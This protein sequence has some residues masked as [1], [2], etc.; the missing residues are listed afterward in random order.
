MTKERWLEAVDVAKVT[1]VDIPK[2][3]CLIEELPDGR[4]R[5]TYTAGWEQQYGSPLVNSIAL[6]KT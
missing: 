3:M 1:R 4:L 5:C 6:V 2:K